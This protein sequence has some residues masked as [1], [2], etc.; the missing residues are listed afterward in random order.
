MKGQLYVVSAPSGAGKTSLVTALVDKLTDVVISVSHTTR[1]PRVGEEHGKHYYFTDTQQFQKQI[2]QNEFLEY[3]KVFDNYY[4]TS[5]VAVDALLEEG[6][7]VI[8]EIDW[9]GAA[10]ICKSIDDVV[11]IFILPPS[12]DELEVRLKKRCQDS[13]EVI[14]RRMRDAMSDMSHCG[15]FNYIVVNNDFD[16]ALQDLIGIFRSNR[17]KTARLI[18]AKD[19]FVKALLDNEA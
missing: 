10:Q 4:G 14:Q 7:D 1:P 9:Q 5:S 11:S 6:K 16:D 2:Q 13:D 12:C 3:A 15:E 17:L 18:A 19:P 8:L